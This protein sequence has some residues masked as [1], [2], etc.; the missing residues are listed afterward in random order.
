LVPLDSGL[1][2]IGHVSTGS[3]AFQFRIDNIPTTEDSA[4][5]AYIVSLKDYQP[6]IMEYMASD[7]CRNELNCLISET[8]AQQPIAVSDYYLPE[9]PESSWRSLGK[10]LDYS[11]L[12]G[13]D[14]FTELDAEILLRLEVQL[15]GT[16]NR[17][18]FQGERKVIMCEEGH[19]LR[20]AA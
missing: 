11:T 2:T 5:P 18:Q 13:R 12:D 10:R 16:R 14:R 19:S 4:A 20:P 17:V 15:Q 9:L 6:V 8:D 7:Y 1:W 3:P